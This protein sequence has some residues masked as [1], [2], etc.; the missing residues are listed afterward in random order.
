L[1]PEVPALTAET[2]LAL[3]CGLVYPIVGLPFDFV[4]PIGC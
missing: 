3:S 1:P 4:C 2:I